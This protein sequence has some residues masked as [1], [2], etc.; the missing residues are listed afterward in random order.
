MKAWDVIG[1]TFDGAAY[2][3]DHG[4]DLPAEERRPI[5]AV[6]EVPAEWCCDTCHEP[7]LE[8]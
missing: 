5:F 8:E 6:D 2:C 3:V 1:Y 4:K 7:I